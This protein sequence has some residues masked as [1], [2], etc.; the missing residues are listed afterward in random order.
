MCREQGAVA[1][2]RMR[3]TLLDVDRLRTIAA[4]PE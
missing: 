1:T 2:G 3:I 4:G